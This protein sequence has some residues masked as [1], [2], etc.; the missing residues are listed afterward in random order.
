MK[1][2]TLPAPLRKPASEAVSSLG[3]SGA[4]MEARR[5]QRLKT[6]ALLQTA[7]VPLQVVAVAEQAE[8]I[9]ETAVH[10]AMVRQP[11]RPPL[12]CQM[13]C[14]WC[15]H[16]TVGTA[17]PEVLRIAAY[18][19]QTL[20]PEQLRATQA[21]IHGL[22]QQRQALR[23]DR[24]SHARLPCALLV[25]DRCAIYPVRPLTCRGYNS[26]DARRCEQSLEPGSQV[27]VPSYAPQH[28]LCTFVLDGM[29][30][31]LEESRLDGELLELTAALDIALTV[32]GAAERWLA[33]EKVFAPAR[34]A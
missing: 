7:R 24:R 15:C 11:P 27:V 30:A 14:A 17:A 26:S 10:D 12:A 18:L 33:G 23:P 5:G 31:G 9:A 34:L 19:R 2:P 1:K 3:A 28:R 8:A 22:T 29:R 13:G 4:E 16:K 20:T 25:E 6:V 21:R 32:P